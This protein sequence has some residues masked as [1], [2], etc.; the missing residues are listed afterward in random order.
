MK[1]IGIIGSESFLARNFIK[2]IRDNFERDKYSLNLY[3]YVSESK[4]LAESYKKIDFADISSVN[5]IDFDSDALMI[6]I[7]KTGTVNGFE[8]YNQFITVNEMYLLNILKAYCDHHSS[9]L[10]IYP[11]TRLIYKSSDTHTINADSDIELKSIY[12]VTKYAAEQYMKIY[13]D[14]YGIKYSILHICTPI[15]T[16]LSDYGNYG[17]FEIFKNQA[18]HDREITVFG[19]GKQKKTFTSMRDICKA[20][21]LLIDKGE[22]KQYSYNLGGQDLELIDIASSIADEYNV[23]IVHVEWPQLNKDVD[24]GSV[25]FDSSSFDKEFNMRYEKVL[26]NPNKIR[27]GVQRTPK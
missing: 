8:Q 2:Y 14:T 4:N 11:S 5:S 1:K 12:A 27:G 21:Q 17:T 6:F 23:P 9:A 20:F 24:G 7:G 10:I 25:V 3:D 16:M 18:I 13:H 19:S 22:P 15:G 26:Y